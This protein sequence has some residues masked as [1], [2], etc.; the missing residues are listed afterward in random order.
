MI[1]NNLDISNNL[2]I[3]NNL[4]ISD[5][6]DIFDD[7]PVWIKNSKHFTLLMEDSSPSE[8]IPLE[9]K[10]MIIDDYHINILNVSDEQKLL[11]FDKLLRIVSYWMIESNE[12]FDELIVFIRE[13]IQLFLD[14]II[15]LLVDELFADLNEKALYKPDCNGYSKNSSLRYFLNYYLETDIKSYKEFMLR[16][17]MYHFLIYQFKS[18]TFL[19]YPYNIDSIERFIFYSELLNTDFD[20]NIS[21]N[22]ESFNGENQNVSLES[23]FNILIE[24]IQHNVEEY[25]SKEYFLFLEE[26]FNFDI[27]NLKYTSLKSLAEKLFS[28]KFYVFGYDFKINSFPF[29]N[30]NVNDSYVK[31]FIELQENNVKIFGFLLEYQMNTRYKLE[32]DLTSI[33]NFSKNM[34]V[35]RKI[36]TKEIYKKTI[37]LD[38]GHFNDYI[39]LLVNSDKHFKFNTCS[40]FGLKSYF[41]I[42]LNEFNRFILFS[43][44]EKIM[45]EIFDKYEDRFNLLR[46]I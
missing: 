23:F 36:N 3:S 27:E 15:P 1:F 16:Y 39:E 37:S 21:I 24:Y 26:K 44:L 31:I 11:L 13:N 32:D 12:V 25:N 41:T 14:Y 45:I 22:T 18:Y 8:K 6:L 4:D 38:E 34:I 9:C 2:N 5:N 30:N 46:R 28:C 35:R 43:S 33:I 29:T 10:N 19:K 20:V 17:I 7:I 40:I 42:E